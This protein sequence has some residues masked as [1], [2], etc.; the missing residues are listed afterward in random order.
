VFLF[1]PI[2]LAA[3][4]LPVNSFQMLPRIDHHCFS[5]SHSQ[6]KPHDIDIGNFKSFGK[7]PIDVNFFSQ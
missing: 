5:S 2:L 1:S 7:V 4:I 6:S 3:Y